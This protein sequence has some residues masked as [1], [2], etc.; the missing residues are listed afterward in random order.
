[1]RRK[2]ALTCSQVRMGLTWQ[3]ALHTAF[4]HACLVGRGHRLIQLQVA[5]V[6]QGALGCW[7]PRSCVQK[8]LEAHADLA[9]VGVV[10]CL[11]LQPPSVQAQ[12][13]HWGYNASAR[14][15]EAAP[16][17][18]N[19][20]LIKGTPC[21][22][23]CS[24]ITAS[25]VLASTLHPCRTMVMSGAVPFRYGKSCV[26]TKATPMYTI[27]LRPCTS[28]STAPGRWDS[29]LSTR[30]NNS[31]SSSPAA[32]TPNTAPSGGAADGY[33][34]AASAEAL[35]ELV[36]TILVFLPSSSTRR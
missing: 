20:C 5:A 3:Q 21:V 18:S 1:M 13:L 9:A 4:L 16:V 15:F 27:A 2:C 33:G 14:S 23:T 11:R 26:S 31:L 28:L 12:T 36:K 17:N 22:L 29:M 19:V 6:E 25:A 7:P 35:P 24:S 32:A 10:Q 30:G 34:G 8:G